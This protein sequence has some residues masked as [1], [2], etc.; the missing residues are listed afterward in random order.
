MGAKTTKVRT[1]KFF[2]PNPLLCRTV[3]PVCKT[4]SIPVSPKSHK[5]PKPKGVWEL[6]I[7][8][9]QAPNQGW[10][11]AWTKPESKLYML[12]FKFSWQQPRYH[13]STFR[14]WH[15]GQGA[16]QAALWV[17]AESVPPSLPAPAWMSPPPTCNLLG[18]KTL[19]VLL[20]QGSVPFRMWQLTTVNSAKKS[21]IL[22]LKWEKKKRNNSHCKRMILNGKLG[23]NLGKAG[24]KWFQDHLCLLR[25]K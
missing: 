24:Q 21:N 9:H 4:S 6:I 11:H 22:L 3:S 25:N 1:T 5:V 10:V 17:M 18:T 7:A 12:T 2:L 19:P 15:P 13:L 14:D 23:K 8:S 16:T 20:Q